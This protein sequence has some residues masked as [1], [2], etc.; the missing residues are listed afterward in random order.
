M[1]ILFLTVLQ[2]FDEQMDLCNLL[3]AEDNQIFIDSHWTFK[4]Q[5]NSLPYIKTRINSY[6]YSPK[7][8]QIR[9]NKALQAKLLMGSPVGPLVSLLL[10]ASIWCRLVSHQWVYWQ[11]QGP[12]FACR[13][14]FEKENR[15]F[16]LHSPTDLIK[17]SW[18]E[19]S[20][21]IFSS[22]STRDIFLKNLIFWNHIG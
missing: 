6:N 9:D 18:K 15:S 5:L 3:K 19:Y 1:K 12:D 16:L 11:F 8:V 2:G 21:I 22:L 13:I 7:T 20:K 17:R 14:V 10:G 4:F